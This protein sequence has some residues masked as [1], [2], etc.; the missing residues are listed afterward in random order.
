MTD[1]RKK[2]TNTFKNRHVKKNT[3][4]KSKNKYPNLNQ[5]LEKYCTVEEILE[6][7]VPIGRK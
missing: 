4:T 1:T 7:F 2:K 3:E 6:E 5:H